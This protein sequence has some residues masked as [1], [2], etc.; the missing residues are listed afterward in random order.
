M[1]VRK[2]ETQV[3][4]CCKEALPDVEPRPRGAARA[5]QR[6]LCEACWTDPSL[7]YVDCKH[8]RV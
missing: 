4:Q 7:S 2:M 3:C 8:G 5:V 6:L 1:T